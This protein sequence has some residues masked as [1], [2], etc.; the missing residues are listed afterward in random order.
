MKKVYFILAIFASILLESCT[1]TSVNLSITTT[2]PGYNGNYEGSTTQ[3]TTS[4]G[5]STSQPYDM[6]LNVSNGTNTNQISIQFG[7]YM[8]PAV[9]SG[10]NFTIQSTSF[11]SQNIVITGS[12]SFSGNKMI[13]DYIQTGS[14]SDTVRY[15]GML[16]KY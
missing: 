5:Q 11:P 15:K 3:T 14:N 9:L 1:R 10:S 13:I 12:G 2:I 4:N 6:I 7:N 8:T 16:V